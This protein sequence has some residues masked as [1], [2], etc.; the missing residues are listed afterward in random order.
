METAGEWSKIAYFTQF[1]TRKCSSLALS[2]IKKPE[3]LILTKDS[4]QKMSLRWLQHKTI[5]QESVS[6]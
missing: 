2:S 3:I 4:Q 1:K 5:L 6:E